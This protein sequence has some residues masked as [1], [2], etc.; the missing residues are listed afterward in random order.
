MTTF[1][2]LVADKAGLIPWAQEMTARG[3]AQR[4]DLLAT[5]AANLDDK[6]AV[7]K[8]AE[9]AKEHGGGSAAATLGTALHRMTELADL[10]RH[11]PDLHA[12][13]IGEYRACLDRHG[14]EILPEWVEQLVLHDE[15][16]AAGTPDRIVRW[17][18]RY[19]VADLKTGADLR[20]AAQEIAI[21]LHGY[22]SASA[23]W[24][25]ATESRIDLPDI[26]QDV[27][28]VVHL[29]A[30]GTGCHLKTVDLRAGREAAERCLWVR[31]WR[32][33]RDLIVDAPEPEP[34]NVRRLPQRI[35][36][37]NTEPVWTPP[38]EGADVDHAKTVEWISAGVRKL[39][40]DTEHATAIG[41]RV[42]AWTRDGLRGGRDWAITTRTCTQRRKA[43]HRAAVRLASMEDDDVACLDLI[44]AALPEIGVQPAMTVGVALGALTTTDA[45][46]LVGTLDA[47]AAGR[48]GIQIDDS[49]RPQLRAV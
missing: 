8:A 41:Q 45:A 11:V 18:G 31:E 7:R 1:A 16:Q 27:A 19:V 24:D 36:P 25:P 21:Q 39:A 6:S 33:R 20:Y 42:G 10:G 12:D 15:Y 13:R 26:D 40:R 44:A 32:K 34:A 37:L 23:G 4:P 29:P 30:Q 2:S 14:I 28:L 47:I 35:E 3:L 43:I 46:A 48:T 38:D 5:V 9:Q 49:G 22:A 17:Q